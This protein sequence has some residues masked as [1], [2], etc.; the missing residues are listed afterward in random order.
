M[1]VKMDK[2][3]IGIAIVVW[4][5]IVAVDLAHGFYGILSLVGYAVIGI[6]I[7]ILLSWSGGKRENYTVV[8]TNYQEP[9]QP[10]PIPFNDRR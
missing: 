2:T 4:S 6:Y 9:K 8:T 1:E 3:K 7:W 5:V 10:K